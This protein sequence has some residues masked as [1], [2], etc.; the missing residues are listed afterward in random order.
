MIRGRH[1]G[2]GLRHL[3]LGAVRDRTVA[4]TLREDLV[5]LMLDPEEGFLI[6]RDTVEALV[7]SGVEGLDWNGVAA[8][9]HGLGDFDDHRLTIDL[10]RIV[11]TAAFSDDEVVR[12]VL[13]SARDTS[14]GRAGATLHILAMSIPASRASGILG[15]MDAE[16]LPG[17][18]RSDGV[19]DLLRFIEHLVEAWLEQGGLDPLALWRWVSLIGTRVS[20]VR[21]DRGAISDF[22]RANDDAR[23]RIQRHVLLD[24]RDDE[25]DP[26]WRAHEMAQA[27]PALHP[28]EDDVVELIRAAGPPPED[29]VGLRH[30]VD[31][32]SLVRHTEDQGARVRAV[33]QEVGGDHPAIAAA[34][35]ELEN[36][37]VPDWKKRENEREARNA[38][39]RER[40]RAEWRAAFDA[41]LDDL[42]A[43]GR[44]ACL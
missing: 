36:P 13:T 31:M 11:G 21:S 2:L 8:R 30:W 17:G 23:R 4:E 9:L 3:I 39:E 42:R 37:Q 22:L 6:R 24:A 41:H 38:A 18:E 25:R 12:H 15:R 10:M 32:L 14:E 33:A 40:R 16:D 20:D 26:W 19:F 7:R 34:I 27:C 1:E 28:S 44:W 5:A 29:E 35:H 43:G